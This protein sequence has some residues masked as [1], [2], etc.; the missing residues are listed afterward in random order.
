MKK[1][2]SIIFLLL[3]GCTAS[4]DHLIIKRTPTESPSISIFVDTTDEL[5]SYLKLPNNSRETYNFLENIFI[6]NDIQI[7][8]TS[9]E[10]AKFSGNIFDTPATHVF[11]F[12]SRNHQFRL[13]EKRNLIAKGTFGNH[14]P[15]RDEIAMLLWE[16]GL[17]KDLPEKLKPY[18]SQ[19]QSK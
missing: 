12:N 17:K 1:L 15:W 5:S 7:V 10:S 11:T 9:T 2:F 3:F 18:A 14:N 8:G 6:K 13:Y 16:T 4:Y 19:N